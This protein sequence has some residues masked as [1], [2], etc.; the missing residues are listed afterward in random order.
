[1]YQFS[2]SWDQHL[3][4]LFLLKNNGEN[5]KGNMRG[6]GSEPGHMAKS[7]PGN[8]VPF[9]CSSISWCQEICN[10]GISMLLSRTVLPSWVYKSPILANTLSLLEARGLLI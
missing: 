9:L 2:P 6:L 7:R 8:S 3:P 5:E 1:M 4:E 10:C